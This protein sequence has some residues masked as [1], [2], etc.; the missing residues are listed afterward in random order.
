MA[1]HCPAERRRQEVVAT[2]LLTLIKHRWSEIR[3][4]WSRSANARA[5]QSRNPGDRHCRSTARRDARPPGRWA[6]HMVQDMTGEAVVVEEVVGVVV[7][8]RQVERPE[9]GTHLSTSSSSSH[10]AMA[11]APIWKEENEI[12]RRQHPDTSAVINQL[13]G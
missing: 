3:T 2:I 11:A 5:A 4:G 12:I 1:H 13:L 10:L 7:V 9:P 6:G 8:Q